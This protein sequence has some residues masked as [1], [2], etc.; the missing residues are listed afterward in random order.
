MKTSVAAVTLAA[1]ASGVA[2]R[3]FTVYNNCPFTTEVLDIHD[4]WKSGRIWGRRNCDFNKDPTGPNS[5]LTGGCNGGLQCAT[6]CGTGVPPATLA[7]FN[8]RREQ[9][10][11]V[12]WFS[13]VD[14]YDLPMRITNT[15]GCPVADCAVDLIPNCPA[16]LKGPYDSNGYA[17][18]CNSACK[19][20][21][22]PNPANDPNCCTGSHGVLE[23]CPQFGVQY[24]DYF[25]SQCK[26]SYVYAFDEP[27]GTALFSCDASKHADYTITL[28]P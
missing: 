21:L 1:F 8:L 13:V 6:T 9:P 14:R 19:A 27:S 5:C 16:P 28:C 7:E 12:R 18:G 2:G 10:R 25:K 11:L 20:G 15:A 22:A 23:T 26:N 24:Y 4:D 17:V 3:T